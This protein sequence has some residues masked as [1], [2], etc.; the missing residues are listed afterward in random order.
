MTGIVYDIVQRQINEGRDTTAIT[1]ELCKFIEQNG[2][3][4]DYKKFTDWGDDRDDEL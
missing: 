3:S 1:N 2:L 4:H